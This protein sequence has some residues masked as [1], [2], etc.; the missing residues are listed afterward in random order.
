ML[1]VI[2]GKKGRL[3]G[4]FYNGFSFA[5]FTVLKLLAGN[6]Q[7]D[8]E[9]RVGGGRGIDRETERKK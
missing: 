7:V 2:K 5:F 9:Q 6:E 1:L 8:E 4:K 3:E